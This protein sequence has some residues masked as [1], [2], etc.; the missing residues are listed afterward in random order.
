MKIGHALII[1]AL[2]FSGCTVFRNATVEIKKDADG[3]VVTSRYKSTERGFVSDRGE[4]V[5]DWA[6]ADSMARSGSQEEFVNQTGKPLHNKG[7]L[8]KLRNGLWLANIYYGETDDELY[9]RVIMHQ[10]KKAELYLPDG[11]Y[12]VRWTEL[13]GSGQEI[14]SEPFFVRPGKIVYYDEEPLGWIQG[15]N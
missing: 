13:S 12:H 10:N 7:Y 6:T 5:G 3:K 11:Y 15:L 2:L 14:K 1:C 4:R 9:T 8:I